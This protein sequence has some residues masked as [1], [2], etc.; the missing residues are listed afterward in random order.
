MKLWSALVWSYWKIKL[1]LNY[2]RLGSFL[3]TLNSKISTKKSSKFLQFPKWQISQKR[4]LKKIHQNRL[5]AIFEIRTVDLR[6]ER[7]KRTLQMLSVEMELMWNS[8]N[9]ISMKKF[10]E[11]FLVVILP[12]AFHEQFRLVICWYILYTNFIINEF[13]CQKVSKYKRKT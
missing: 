8:G 2:L 9:S 11:T 4:P 10:G 7:S 6:G 3:F 1:I 13:L 5:L 12:M